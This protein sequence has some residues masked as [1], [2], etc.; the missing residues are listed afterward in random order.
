MWP[1]SQQP[2]GDWYSFLEEFRTYEAKFS[3]A[4]KEDAL[5]DMYSLWLKNHDESLRIKII[6]LVEE[7]KQIEPALNFERLLKNLEKIKV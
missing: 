7:I 3:L 4:E 2:M 6:R 1:N 5:L